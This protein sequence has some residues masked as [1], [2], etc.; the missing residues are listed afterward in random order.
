MEREAS[1]SL[2]VMQQFE[3]T[4]TEFEKLSRLV[5]EQCGINLSDGKKELVRARLGKRIRSGQFGSFRN[6]Y[7]SVVK[8]QSGQ[9]LVYLLDT[10]STNF[11]FFFREQEHFSYLRSEI[12]PALMGKKRS[13]G[14]S[15]R[16]WSAG[17]SSGEE[18]YSIAIT[19]L[20]EVENPLAWSLSILAT[21]ISTKVLKVAESGVFHKERIQ[22]IPSLLV[23]KY[24]LKG[25]RNWQDFVRVKDHV[26]EHIQFER[27]NLMESFHF[28]GA[29][30]C[31]FCR[32]VMIYF[33][34][35]TQ[36]D[37]VNRFCGCLEKGG[38]LLIGHSES[39]A[40]ISHPFR[41]VR[42]AVYKK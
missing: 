33:D 42:P 40:G 18:P 11:T 12:L 16:F 36:A 37:L 41:Y 5:Y 2:P 35:K 9:E 15:L 31:I 7:Q 3:L 17:C 30:D 10:I 26:K 32:N 39:L 28:K 23:K 21:D 1:M 24:F 27:L 34:K 38:F 29:F 14:R 8:D 13:N 4:D 25:D 6:Y 19:L 20:E 22:S